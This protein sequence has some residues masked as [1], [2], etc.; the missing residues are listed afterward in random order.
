[1]VR[2]VTEA[3]GAASRGV[4]NYLGQ[5]AGRFSSAGYLHFW[6][7]LLKVFRSRV[8]HP[9]ISKVQFLQLRERLEV[10]QTEITDRVMEKMQAESWGEVREMGNTTS[11][12]NKKD[13]QPVVASP[14]VSISYEGAGNRT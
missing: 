9:G 4:S 8:R 10:L 13:L 2:Q 1:M 7:C 3:I 6:Q 12:P 11:E 14:S 5:P